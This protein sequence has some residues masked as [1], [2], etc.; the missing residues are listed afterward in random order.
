MRFAVWLAIILFALGASASTAMP[1]KAIRHKPASEAYEMRV[2]VVYGERTTEF[3]VT[4]SGNDGLLKIFQRGIEGKK[5]LDKSEIELLLDTYANLPAVDDV[6]D[7]CYR[8]K[9]KI[10]MVRS[11][12][13]Q[14]VKASCFA[15]ESSTEPAFRHFANLLAQPF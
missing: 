14:E 8:A 2:S 12:R 6:P 13:P 3:S 7:V 10:V 11:G 9:I 1:P 15:A 4:S 5:K